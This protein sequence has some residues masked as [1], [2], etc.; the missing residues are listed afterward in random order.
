MPAHDKDDFQKVKTSFL[1]HHDKP[2]IMECFTCAADEALANDALVSS[3]L[4]KPKPGVIKHVVK[5][6]LG[7]SGV[8]LRN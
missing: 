3:Q 1:S 2:V 8:S 4:I 5:N 7:D 6:I